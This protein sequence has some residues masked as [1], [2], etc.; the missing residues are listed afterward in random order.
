MGIAIPDPAVKRISVH[1]ELLLRWSGKVNLTAVRDI[2]GMAERLYLDSCALLPYLKEAC[3]LHDVGSGAGFP[4]LVLKAV[5]SEIDLTLT[6]ARR[7]K[8]SFLKEAAR[9]MGFTRGVRVR[10]ERIGIRAWRGEPA[11]QEV[12]SRA[13]FPPKIWLDLGACLVAPGG[14]LWLMAGQPIEADEGL[15]QLVQPD[16]WPRGF[17]LELW[18]SYQ[19]PFCGLGRR[20]AAFR[21]IP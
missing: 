19:L 12:V 8:I 1:R 15:E 16:C 13:S 6:E 14:R 17:E 20:L 4:G 18:T 21:R 2:K 9:E 7:K 11:W 10:W 3:S 5:Q